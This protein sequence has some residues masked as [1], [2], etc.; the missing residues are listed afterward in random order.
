MPK[1]KEKLNELQHYCYLITNSKNGKVYVGTTYKNIDERFKEHIK[2]SNFSDDTK[3]Q[4]IH[5]AIA[6]YGKDNFS[7]MVLSEHNLA[8]KLSAKKYWLK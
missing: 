1:D 7:I 3:K 8:E 6:K 2:V 5:K 4:A